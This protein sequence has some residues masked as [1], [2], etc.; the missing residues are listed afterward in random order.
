MCGIM[1]FTGIHQAYPIVIEGLKKLE[2]R[3]YDSA[4][5]ALQQ[6]QIKIYKKEGKVAN[7][8]THCRLCH[9]QANTGIGHT[10][11]ATHGQPSDNNSHP[12][13][14]ESQRYAIVHNGIIENYGSIKEMLMNYG[15]HFKSDTDTEVLVQLIDWYAH[16]YDLSTEEAIQRTLESVEGSF[17]FAVLD[18][19][20]PGQV[21]VARR[22]SPLVIG[23]GVSGLYASSDPLT[24]VGYTTDIIY[25]EEDV[26]G[27]LTQEGEARF[28]DADLQQI[29]L[30]AEKLEYVSFQASKEGH[31]SYMLKEILEQPKSIG[32]A[33]S[34]YVNDNSLLPNFT[35]S[36]DHMIE[37]VDRIIIT[38]CGTSF[39]SGLVAEYLI[40][41][42]AHLSVEVEYASEF[43][44]KCPFFSAKDLVIGISQS[45]ETADTL[46]ALELAKTKGAKTLAFV[47]HYNSSIARLVD[48]VI[49]LQAGPEISVASTKAFTSQVTVLSIFAAHL[50]RKR[51]KLSTAEVRDLMSHMI[52]VPGQI[53]KV[54]SQLDTVDNMTCLLQNTQ[55]SIF[56]GRSTMYPL[57]LE[58]ALKLKE[59]SYIHAEGYAGG[60]MK[61]GP[62][63][64][65]DAHMPVF[66]LLQ[67]DNTLSKMISNVQESKA[68]NAKVIII[69]TEDVEMPVGCADYVITVPATHQFC[70]SLL[71]TIPLQLISYFVAKQRGCDIDQPRNLAKSVTVE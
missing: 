70:Q 42:Y 18:D 54:L 68:R 37:D 1:A 59:I 69:K 17:A 41:Q 50:A 36:I 44:Y 57:A 4:G 11:W 34:T 39:H 61:H 21:Y 58:G 3:G 20:H 14:S 16:R 40:E 48:E 53:D 33:L 7:L 46:A 31:D 30:K 51:N 62:I 28:Y 9:T 2:Y 43:R 55:S 71:H 22:Q 38:A 67:N 5:V 19:Q 27:V 49:Y 25:L 26:I 45:G 6:D 8:D 60:E 29:K 10:R 63:A 23:L 66:A 12:H 32:R 35:D 13:L 65:L 47:N 64:L 52:K 15:M 24:I 56:L